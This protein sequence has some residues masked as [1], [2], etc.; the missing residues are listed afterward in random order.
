MASILT[1]SLTQTYNNQSTSTVIL[2]VPTEIKIYINFKCL[3]MFVKDW[4]SSDSYSAASIDESKVLTII[5]YFLCNEWKLVR[6]VANVQKT[7]SQIQKV[8]DFEKRMD[9]LPILSEVELMIK[10]FES[11]SGGIEIVI[12]HTL[13]NFL[14]LNCYSRFTHAVC[15]SRQCANTC[16][17]K[18]DPNI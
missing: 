1:V 18:F 15:N 17:N 14:V 5:A 9:S 7:S 3:D 13:S 16:T 10:S 4:Q 12:I 2:R 6:S 11:Y 8:F